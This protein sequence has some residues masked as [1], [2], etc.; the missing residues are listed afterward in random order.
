MM[1]LD[2]L[3]LLYGNKVCKLFDNKEVYIVGRKMIIKDRA[4]DITDETVASSGMVCNETVVGL[5]CFSKCTLVS[6]ISLKVVDV[7]SYKDIKTVDGNNTNYVIAISIE[8]NKNIIVMDNELNI[9][10]YTYTYT[11]FRY[12]VFGNVEIVGNVIKAELIYT[13]GN[14]S[15]Q[16]EIA[17]DMEI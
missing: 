4:V 17:I 7:F 8:D 10:G 2:K 5:I 15:T 12:T 1:N 3:R 9:V 14:Q 6:T 16:V 13:I 11:Y